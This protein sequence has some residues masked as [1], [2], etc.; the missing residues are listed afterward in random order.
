MCFKC[1][2]VFL[3]I[4]NKLYLLCKPSS[5]ALQLVD[6]CIKRQVG[7][8]LLL[9]SHTLWQDVFNGWEVVFDPAAGQRG[10]QLGFESQCNTNE[11]KHIKRDNQTYE[12]IYSHFCNWVISSLC[13]ASSV[14]IF[15]IPNKKIL[16][17]SNSLNDLLLPLALPGEKLPVLEVKE[18]DGD[19]AHLIF[20]L[21]C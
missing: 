13:S 4:R 7:W 19:K 6:P 18:Y 3:C 8:H 17:I 14:Y 11:S 1:I 9:L 20:W 5:P 15:Y 12:F 2:R 10:C 21:D 16:R